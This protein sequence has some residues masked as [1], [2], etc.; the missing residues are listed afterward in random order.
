VASDP[1]SC[2]AFWSV[3][4]HPGTSLKD[5]DVTCKEFIPSVI[6]DLCLRRKCEPL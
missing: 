5:G 2:S 1:G 6:S 3:G 4:H